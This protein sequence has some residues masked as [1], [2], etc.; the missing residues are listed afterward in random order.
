MQQVMT[1]NNPDTSVGG[2][3]QLKLHIWDTAGSEQFRAMTSLYYKDCV[4]AVICYD[5]TS[6]KS[7]NSVS[8]WVQQMLNNNNSETGEVVMALAANK[9]D[10]DPALKKIP[11]QTAKELA[12]KHDMVYAETSA[13]TNEGIQHM[14]K[15][16]A[17]KILVLKLKELAEQ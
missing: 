5:Q 6:E 15:R 3:L 4:G 16:L 12:K 8:Y 11:L 9:S 10:L 14:F 13:K 2:T 17:E 7:F 1:L